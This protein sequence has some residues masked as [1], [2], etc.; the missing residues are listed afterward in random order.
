[1]SSSLASHVGSR[2]G[3]R[4][5]EVRRLVGCGA[6]GAIAAAFNAPFTG[7]FYAFEL[8]IGLYSVSLLAPLV[9]ASLVASFTA[10]WLGA[11]QTSIDLTDIKTLSGSDV[12]PF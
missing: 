8:I 6:A 3:L 4:R 5:N 12:V 11:V 2:L 1:M 9:A 10:R 7:A